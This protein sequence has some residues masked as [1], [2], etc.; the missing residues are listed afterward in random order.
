MEKGEPRY[1]TCV[2]QADVHEGWREHRENGG[3]VIDVKTN[4]IVCRGLS[5]PHSPRLLRGNY[6]CLN[7]GNGLFWLCLYSTKENL[8]ASHFIRDIFAVLS[9]TNH[10]AI[11][12]SSKCRQNGT[13]SGLRTR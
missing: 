12:G 2:A 7:H 10:F 1:V 6:G 13:F 8:N 5:M 3:S 9:F 11:V 4:E